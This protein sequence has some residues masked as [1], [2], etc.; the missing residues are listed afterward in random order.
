M[1]SGFDIFSA[2]IIL[3]FAFRTMYKGFM[4]EF[5]TLG[6]LFG[7]LIAAALLSGSVANMIDPLFSRMIW[8]QIV[9]FLLV[10]VVVYIVVK[11]LH[12]TLEHVLES[13]YLVNADRALGFCFGIIEGGAIVIVAIIIIS[14]VPFI[15]TN[16]MLGDSV[17]AR[18]LSPLIPT[19]LRLFNR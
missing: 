2:I 1:I 11:I 6:A 18:V 15:N 4:H 8:S 5:L 7:G 10:F 3:F 9:S 14:T 17:V 13:V 12:H 19:I 16:A